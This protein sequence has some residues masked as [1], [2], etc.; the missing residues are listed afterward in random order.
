VPG[1]RLGRIPA[2]WYDSHVRL[3]VRG[4]GPLARS[5][6][7]GAAQGLGLADDGWFGMGVVRWR[8]WV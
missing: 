1:L 4:N 3:M 5:G 6:S 7:A 2:A 8:R